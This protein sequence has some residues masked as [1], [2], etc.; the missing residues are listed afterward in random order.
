MS[1]NSRIMAYI[2]PRAPCTPQEWAAFDLACQLQEEYEQRPEIA[3]LSEMPA[4]IGSFTVNGFSVTMTGR[5]QAASLFPGGLCPEARAE[6]F[7]AGLLYR[8]VSLC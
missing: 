7:N 2:A 6:L 3:Q 5:G 8:G 1:A 4:G